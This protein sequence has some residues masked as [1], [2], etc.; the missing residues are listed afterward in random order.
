MSKIKIVV[1]EGQG[2]KYIAAVTANADVDVLIEIPEVCRHTA[3]N[4]VVAGRTRNFYQTL[5]RI[6]KTEVEDIHA[7]FDKIHPPANPLKS[8]VEIEGVKARTE[9]M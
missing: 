9:A 5:T 3:T 8:P 4:V 6:D 1:M 2:G 7:G